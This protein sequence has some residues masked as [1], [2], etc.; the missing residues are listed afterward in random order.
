MDKSFRVFGTI[1]LIFFIT[2]SILTKLDSKNPPAQISN[3][4]GQWIS[5]KSDQLKFST[6]IPKTWQINQ[7]PNINAVFFGSDIYIYR[8]NK[9]NK[10]DFYKVVVQRIT[11]KEI[12]LEEFYFSST[13][14]GEGRSNLFKKEIRGDYILYKSE[15]LG[16]QDNLM[17]IFITNDNKNFL[18]YSI[19]PFLKDTPSESQNK[20]IEYFDQIINSTVLQ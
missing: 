2:I 13:V 18:R 14:F 15:S 12:S 5:F 19:A 1:F 3:S 8:K 9:E 17:S 6:V 7:Y 4:N 10:E 20:V 16:T 11:L